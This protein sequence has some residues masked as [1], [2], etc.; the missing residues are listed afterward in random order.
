MSTW[1]CDAKESLG[2]I[3]LA[4]RTFLKNHQPSAI[5]VAFSG[6]PDSL[7][8]AAATSWVA[9]V[10]GPGG[11]PLPLAALHVD[12]AWNPDSA[13]QALKAK[14]LA[15]KV[16][17]ERCEI[18]RLAPAYTPG[19]S[20]AK[21]L[22]LEAAAS[23][24]RWAALRE[25]AA[26]FAKENGKK[27]VC[28]ITG[29]SADD[30]GETVLLGLARGSGTRS[31]AG[32]KAYESRQNREGITVAS[33]KP[34]LW[35]RRCQTHQAC[36]QLGLTPL[37]DPSN[38]SQI[39]GMPTLRRALL[40]SAALPALQQSLGQDP[41]MALAR[42]AA[43]LREDEE[44]LSRQSRQVLKTA[45][46]SADHKLMVLKTGVLQDTPKAILR[47][48]LG[49]AGVAMGWDASQIKHAHY[50]ALVALIT[51]WHGQGPL[52]LPGLVS[53]WRAD[54]YLYLKREETKQTSARKTGESNLEY[55][56][57]QSQG[58]LA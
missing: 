46:I 51:D 44:E 43:L 16:G 27:D 22:G 55:E 47:R 5:L 21:T 57:N 35:I 28:I 56:G 40:R 33:G 52:Q 37:M 39:P 36:K 7:A 29:H 15:Q 32:M 42:T 24:G 1:E 41:I 10:A 45:Q 18:R 49:Q 50:L 13:G 12:H 31:L 3:Q 25:F 8:L 23:L 48:V 11:Q 20:R 34:L 19:G 6:G 26:S 14:D 30:Q 2:A 4:V 9:Q 58:V 54:G 17:I 38:H 53:A